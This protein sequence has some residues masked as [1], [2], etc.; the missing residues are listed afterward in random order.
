LKRETLSDLIIRKVKCQKRVK[1]D[2]ENY[3]DKLIDQEAIDKAK[4]VDQEKF[5]TPSLLL[6]KY[7]GTIRQWFLKIIN[8]PYFETYMLIIILLNTIQI[9]IENPLSNPN[10]SLS[11]I[12]N[13][14]DYIMTG[15]FTLEIVAKI[16]ANGLFFCGER[17]FL[18]NYL[19][20]MDIGIVVVSVRIFHIF[21]IL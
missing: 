18:A 8:H 12:M 13:I 19:N 3:I 15:V 1:N 2:K 11:K 17:S 4:K 20:F 9:A 5:E 21:D 7:E 14:V 6:F 10:T 16:I